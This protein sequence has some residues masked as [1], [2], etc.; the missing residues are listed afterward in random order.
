MTTKRRSVFISNLSVSEEDTDLSEHLIGCGIWVLDFVRYHLW[1][2]QAN[3][4][5]WM[6]QNSI[7]INCVTLRYGVKELN[8]AT[9]THIRTFFYF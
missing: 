6:F 9:G 7:M 3:L 1:V 8:C 2:P 5:K 4:T